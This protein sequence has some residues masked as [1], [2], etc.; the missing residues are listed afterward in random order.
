M[1]AALA[2]GNRRG[3]NSR[4]SLLQIYKNSSAT[5]DIFY[6]LLQGIIAK[7]V[8]MLERFQSGDLGDLNLA[9]FERQIALR[10][11][12]VQ[13]ALRTQEE[14]TSLAI[15]IGFMYRDAWWLEKHGDAALKGYMSRPA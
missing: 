15:K 12:T 4:V 2:R 8:E 10:N 6:G 11:E 9:D 3:D 14:N 5:V 13:S 7:R 1:R